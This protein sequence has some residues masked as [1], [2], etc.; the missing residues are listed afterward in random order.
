MEK[1]TPSFLVKN[2][3]CGES[4]AVRS[5]T[6]ELESTRPTDRHKSAAARLTVSGL[7]RFELSSNG[8]Q[9]VPLTPRG[10][11]VCGDTVKSQKGG[12]G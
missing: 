2:R 1:A 11:N 3:V 8:Q 12:G 4:A 7:S 10:P 6:A 9:T 5:A